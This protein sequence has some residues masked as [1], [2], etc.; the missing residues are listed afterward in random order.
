M[1]ERICCGRRT[2]GCVNGCDR[3]LFQCSRIRR[4]YWQCRHH[5]GEHPDASV[6][7]VHGVRCS[8][9]KA[10]AHVRE[11]RIRQ[12]LAFFVTG[13]RGLRT[14]E[15]SQNREQDQ[16]HACES[17][18]AHALG[19]PRERFMFRA[20]FERGGAGGLLTASVRA[21]LSHV[22][23]LDRNREAATSGG[24]RLRSLPWHRLEYGE[25][26]GHPGGPLRLVTP[27]KRHCRT[28]E[29]GLIERTRVD[30]VLTVSADDPTE[31]ESAAHCAMVAHG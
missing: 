12:S 11:D 20:S 8:R 26:C 17:C 1:D 29:R 14:D 13:F 25:S 4:R 7:V 19:P 27:E 9:R 6:L 31:H 28:K 15:D 10:V 16:E 5:L 24:S 3:C 18:R 2:V 22:A 30:R 21:S 23:R